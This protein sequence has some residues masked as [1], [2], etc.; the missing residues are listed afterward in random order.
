MNWND[1][2]GA[3]TPADPR[4]REPLVGDPTLTPDDPAGDWLKVLDT[5]TPAWALDGIAAR[6]ATAALVDFRATLAADADLSAADRAT[7]IGKATPMIHDRTRAAVESAWERLH[8]D[9]SAI[10]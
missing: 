6:L 9:A 8:T 1:A 3:T 7:I 10:H 5:S 4:A 2:I